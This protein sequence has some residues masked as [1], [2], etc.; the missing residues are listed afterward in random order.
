MTATRREF[1]IG[2]AALAAGTAVGQAL[3]P[4]IQTDPET[5][6][7]Y[8]LVDRAP[9]GCSYWTIHHPEDYYRIFYKGKTLSAGHGIRLVF[10]STHLNLNMQDTVEGLIEQ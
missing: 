8:E 9:C 6:E 3:D 5:G 4:S 2:L 1:L 7:L 10:C